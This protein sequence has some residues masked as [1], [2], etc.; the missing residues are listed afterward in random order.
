LFL[1]YGSIP[2]REKDLESYV[3]LVFT[4]TDEEVNAQYA[5][6]PVVM[7]KYRLLKTIFTEEGYLN[8]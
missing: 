6:Y 5:Q 8:R 3:K 4:S 1:L 2:S 7:Q